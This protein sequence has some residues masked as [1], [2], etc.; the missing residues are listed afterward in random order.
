MR[1]RRHAFLSL[2]LPPRLLSHLLSD[3]VCD[4]FFSLPIFPPASLCNEG[5]VQAS[6]VS[7]T[8]PNSS[9]TLGTSTTG[10]GCANTCAGSGSCSCRR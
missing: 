4:E 10:C 7:C 3:S 5:S 9:G 8:C 1:P 2:A 6:N